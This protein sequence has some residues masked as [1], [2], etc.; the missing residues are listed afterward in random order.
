MNNLPLGTVTF[1]F[2]DIVGSTSL[3]ERNADSMKDALDIHNIALKG[4][5]ETHR[6]VIFKTVGNSFQAA[7]ATAT[8]ALNAAIDGQISLQSSHWNIL[9]PLNVRMGLHTGEAKLDPG[10][11][12]YTVSHTKNRAARIMSSAHGGQILLSQETAELVARSLADGVTLKDLGT[13]R[14]KG[15]DLPEH[16]FQVQT[17]G[18]LQEF[19][20]LA[21]SIA[22]PN[23]LP[24]RLTYFIGREKETEL[25]CDLL[26]EYRLVTLT[27]SGGTGKTRLALHVASL[28]LDHY[29]NG[30]WLVELAPLTDPTLIPATIAG[31]LGLTETSGR[32]IL[33]SLNDFLRQKN[34]LLI[35]DNCEHLPE[36][37]AS[38]VDRLLKTCPELTILVTSRELLG[39][40][41]ETPYRVPPMTLPDENQQP[42]VSQLTEYDSVRLFVERARMFLPGFTIT[43]NN[44]V[45]ITQVVNRL[46]GIPLAIEL[47]A[48]RLRMFSVEQIAARLKDAF[49]LLTGGG[50]SGLPHHQTL[51][52]LIDWSYN[53]LSVPE[54][55][56]LRRLSV[57]AGGWTLE[58]AEQVC[59]GTSDV[60]PQL[61]PEDIFD[62]LSSLVD[63]SLVITEHLDEEVRFSLLETIRKYAHEKLVDESSAE[64]IRSLHL[65][66]YV[67]LVRSQEPE[68][69][70][71]KQI[72]TLDHLERELDNLRHA[73]EWALHNEVNT[74]L[75]LAAALK[76]F[77]HI[78]YHWSEG[79]DW[80][81]N[82][83]AALERSGSGESKP[84]QTRLLRARALS[85]LGFHL[86]MQSTQNHPTLEKAKAS[87]VESLAIYQENEQEQS[88]EIRSGKAWTLL[89]LGNYHA[90]DGRKDLA[91]PI[92]QEALDLFRVSD[93]AHGIAECLQAFGGMESDPA[94]RIKIHQEQLAVE[95]INGDIEGI[96]TALCFI[97]WSS[98]LNGNYSEALET[99]EASLAYYEEVYNPD[100]IAWI[101]SALG[102][103]A[104][105]SGDLPRAEQCLTQSLVLNI[106]LRNEGRTALCLYLQGFLTAAEGHYDHAVEINDRLTGIAQKTENKITAYN[107]LYQ[108]ARIARL[109]GDHAMAQDFIEQT[110]KQNG[111]PENQKMLTHVELGHL[112]MQNESLQQAGN[113]W[114]EAIQILDKSNDLFWTGFPMDALAYLA[115]RENDLER[116]ACLFGTRWSQGIFYFLS[117]DERLQREADLTFI[118][119]SLGG[120]VY[121][122]LFKKGNVM[123]LQ[124]ALRL[125]KEVYYR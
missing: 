103:A 101:W 106:N 31:S 50:R 37:C 73:L 85:A 32:S 51:R 48:S 79:I 84:D 58:A 38:L 89:N 21:S 124:Q 121:K 54:R 12:E 78:R 28:V 14:M 5:I 39:L 100:M 16:L 93:D 1:L 4:A 2:T 113:F 61:Y 80:L 110:Q 109:Q 115:L 24:I 117:P 22:H 107:A 55:I 108:R 52:A 95:E 68:I 94:L 15:M 43:E 7:F 29:P 118:Q 6:G 120:K 23:N 13:H 102:V 36:A 18:L 47:A 33:D 8:D 99:Y 66:Y 96:A 9:G 56:L 74:E 57:F 122:E 70:G 30:A 34:L 105:N 72:Q 17:P 3:W 65:A 91:L 62:L 35:L 111:I 27:G 88:P 19:P 75:E 104:Q 81:S 83:L 76:W 90:Q 69:R 45:A 40:E 77:W 64:Q 26:A 67:G 20:P 86:L 46:D 97:G 98:F 11:D 92:I 41:G 10:G 60:H 82:G 53:L 123:N 42:V 119:A 116:A 59:T 49:R 114:R 63:K 112:A 44:A 25:I 87:L 125:A 71:R